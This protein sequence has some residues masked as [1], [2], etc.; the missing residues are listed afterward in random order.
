MCDKQNKPYIIKTVA[1]E[2]RLYNPDF[3]DDRIC[4]CGHP[5]HRHFDPFE[6]PEEQDVGCKYC[7][8]YNFEEV[9]DPNA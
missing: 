5:Y 4:K 6:E 3:G 7:G 2:V 8:C 1:S 9:G